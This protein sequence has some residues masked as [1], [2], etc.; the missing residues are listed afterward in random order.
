MSISPV[1]PDKETCP[2]Q[3]ALQLI[4]G[5]WKILII[6]ELFAGIQRFNQLQKT[7]TGITHKVL[8]QQLRE[9]EADGIVHREVYPEVPPRVE[10]SLTP[11][12]ESLKPI[13]MQ[14]HHWKIEH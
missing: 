14:M 12:G 13:I 5:R 3:E 6:R 1:N 11:L 9:L 10:Y 8:T 7:L 2:A 4:T